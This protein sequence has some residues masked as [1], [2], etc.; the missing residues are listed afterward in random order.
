MTELICSG[1]AS[2][3]L[4]PETGD[5]VF[6]AWE[7]ED[8][9]GLCKAVTAVARDRAWL[10]QHTVTKLS[11]A[12]SSPVLEGSQANLRGFNVL[13]TLLEPQGSVGSGSAAGLDVWVQRPA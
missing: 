6:P 4:A 8:T 7:K 13:L 12:T 11:Q 1:S 3:F 2:E 9:A 10:C 5:S